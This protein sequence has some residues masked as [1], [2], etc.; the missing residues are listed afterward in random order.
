MLATIETAERDGQPDIKQEETNERS[1]EQIA[2][3]QKVE[4]RA[5]PRVKKL[6]KE[7]GWIGGLWSRLV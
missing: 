7:L 4:K 3:E 1:E 2:T 5:T 6:A